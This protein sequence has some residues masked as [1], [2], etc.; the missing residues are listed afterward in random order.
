MRGGSRSPTFAQSITAK[1][2][3]LRVCNW[4]FL[5]RVCIMVGGRRRYR[6]IGEK[7]AIVQEAYSAPGLIKSTARKYNVEPSNIRRWRRALADNAAQSVR[8]SALT[9][10]SGRATAL[11]SLDEQLREFISERRAHSLGI[12]T[13]LVMIYILETHN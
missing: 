6:T 5:H 1:N 3:L 11:H 7:R 10:N 8:P 4:H 12:S 9:V 13:A 2:F